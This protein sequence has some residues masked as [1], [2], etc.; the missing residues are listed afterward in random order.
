M[1]VTIW[2]IAVAVAFA[3]YTYALYPL[4]LWLV[5]RNRRPPQATRTDWPTVSISLPAYN[6][7]RSIAKTI[8]QLLAT[9][10]PADRRQILVISDCSSD[11]TDEIVKSYASRGVELLRQPTRQGKT[12]AENAGRA[13][14][15]GDI[16]VNT[17]ASVVVAPDAIKALVRALED[18]TVGVASGRDVSIDRVGSQTNAGETGYVDYDMWIRGLESRI[19]G[20]P[21]ASGCLY[22]IR[23]DLHMVPMPDALSRDFGSALV[24]REAGYRAVSVDDALCHVPR[25]SSLRREYRR[26]VRTMNRGIETLFFK[27]RLLNPLR[28]GVFS[29]I[30]FT[31]K[32]CR[33][34][35]PVVFVAA[36]IAIVITGVGTLVGTLALAGLLAS[37]AAGAIGWWWPQSRPMPRLI[38]LPAFLVLGTLAVLHAWIKALRGDAMG[39]WEPT[40]R[41]AM[42]ASGR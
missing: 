40:V 21:G 11:R 38:S 6:E 18:P 19:Y 9:D 30:L 16:V 34:L 7:E 31:H 14:L 8:E 17:D 37:V 4:V 29:W 32:V 26:K 25:T 20:I 39:V 42:P 1:Q 27:R 33:W 35:V 23:R 10:Y 41:E 15:R 13:H 36:A 12:A 3:L 2:L 5:G 22:A 28:Y 24:A